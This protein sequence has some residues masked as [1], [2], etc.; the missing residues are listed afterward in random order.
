MLYQALL[1][2]NSLVEHSAAW[3]SSKTSVQRGHAANLRK[4]SQSHQPSC[5]SNPQ[6]GS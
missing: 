5:Q 1:I 6:P 2:S 3:E 4:A